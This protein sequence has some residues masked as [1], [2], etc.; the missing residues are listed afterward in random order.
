M[1][2]GIPFGQYLLLDKLAVGGMAE[3]FL[4]KRTGEAGFEKTCVVKRVLPYLVENPEFVRMFLDE[5]RLAAR[6]NHP[7]V[8]Q[9]FELGR[10]E[11]SYFIA[12]EYLPGSDLVGLLKRA[13]GPLPID[14]ALRLV[15]QAAEPLHYA[16]TF[17]DETG[18]ALGIVHR[19]I[20][21][22][23]LFVTCQGALKILDFGV[24]FAHVRDHRTET[25]QV[26]GKT[27]YMSPEQALGQPVDGRSD[28]WALGVVA[29]ELLTGKHLFDGATA[30]QIALQVC[31]LPIADVRTLRP[32]LSDR[33]AATVMRAL[34]RDRERRWPNALELQRALEAEL[35][36]S[37]TGNPLAAWLRSL[38]GDAWVSEQMARSHVAAGS[39]R[40][41]GTEALQPAPAAVE[42]KP[43]TAVVTPRRRRW[44]AALVLLPVLALAAWAL[45]PAPVTAPVAVAPPPAPPPV[46]VAVAEP[47]VKPEPAPAPAARAPAPP[48]VR[49]VAKS[50]R[51]AAAPAAA[52]PT[53]AG[54]LTLIT[55]P[56]AKVFFKDREL[57][58]TPLFDVELPAGKLTLRL[59]GE[60]RIERTLS[61]SV[62]ADASTQVR[63]PLEKLSRAP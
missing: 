22:S 63:I 4:A 11:G 6:L 44:P 30:A 51:A 23:N 61:V 7:G 52:K 40:A 32:E 12:M 8:V 41:G 37:S 16:H 9:V 46:A 29:Y 24:A 27:R 62:Q 20:S 33:A 21:P 38:F 57:G 48:P 49:P 54:K 34:E 58:V 31:Q 36:A 10:H 59:V 5:A 25:G 35:P 47:P 15:A 56:Y 14:I 50:R 26:K 39:V 1:R 45:R 53:E 60:D 19:D 17:A 42:E 2:S 18:R 28:V 13:G 43:T 55:K 3:I